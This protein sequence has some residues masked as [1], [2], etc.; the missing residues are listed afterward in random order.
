MTKVFSVQKSLIIKELT[1]GQDEKDNDHEEQSGNNSSD[2]E[3]CTSCI[4]WLQVHSK[5]FYGGGGKGPV[6]N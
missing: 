2:N 3:T 5:P 1:L 6:L 4:S